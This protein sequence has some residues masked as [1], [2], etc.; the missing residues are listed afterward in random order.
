MVKKAGNFKTPEPEK[1]VD[2]VKERHN[3]KPK[4]MKYTSPAMSDGTV[5]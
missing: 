3:Q 2:A 5:P 4:N 1:T